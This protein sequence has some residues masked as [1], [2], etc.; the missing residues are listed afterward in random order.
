MNGDQHK[1]EIFDPFG[2]AY[3]L[4]KGILF[5]PFDLGKWCVIGFA[6]FFSGSWGGGF[7]IN[8]PGG[9]DWK[10][11]STSQHN[12]PASES[13]PD[14]GIPVFVAIAVVILILILVFMW[15]GARGRFIFMDCV[16]KNRAA[17]VAPWQEFRREGN[18]F[19]L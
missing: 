16:V 18:S 12:L 9:G 3:E 8:F 7:H 6:A 1:I 13:F 19:F 5:R 14:W 17:I 10:F 2:A 15:I 4:M 11:R